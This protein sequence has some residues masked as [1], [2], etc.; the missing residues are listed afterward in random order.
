M[1]SHEEEQENRLK[2]KRGERK[3]P[4]NGGLWPGLP[5]PAKRVKKHRLKIPT[6]DR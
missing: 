6:L 4:Q 2:K 3:K 5:Q 1:E